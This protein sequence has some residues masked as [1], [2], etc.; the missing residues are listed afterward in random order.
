VGKL[1]V[2]DENDRNG[3]PSGAIA[4]INVN[5]EHRQKGIGRALVEYAQSQGV[6]PKHNPYMMTSN[7]YGFAQHTPEFGFVSRGAKKQKSYTC[8]ICGKPATKGVL[9]AEGMGIVPSCDEHV[10]QAKKKVDDPN[11]IVGIK[12]LTRKSKVAVRWQDSDQGKL[13]FQYRHVPAKNFDPAEHQII[14]R[15]TDSQGNRA[16]VGSLAFYDVPQETET[17]EGT[18]RPHEIAWISV[19]PELRRKGIGRAMVEHAYSLGYHPTH[20]EILSANGKGFAQATPEFDS[21]AL[22]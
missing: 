3:L 16:P 1:L 10:E 19:N 4:N 6:Y 7:G 2:A 20:S 14:A 13:E 17:Y 15:L 11:D 22:V 5:P 8:K 9:W 18:A 21:G 12:D